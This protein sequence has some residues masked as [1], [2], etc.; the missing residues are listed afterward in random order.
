MKV[1]YNWLQQHIAEKLPEAHAL[2]DVIT[3][4]AFEVEEVSEINDDVVFDI[5]VLPDRA[6]DCLSHVGV[7]REIAGLLGLTLK[8]ET[9]TYPTETL[10]LPIELQSDLTR[11]Y[12]AIQINDVTV[13]SSPKWLKDKLET[14]GQRSINNIVDATNFVM[15]DSGQPVHAFDRAKID[16]G[17]VV[18]LAKP[19]E[20]ITTL[21]GEEKVL[22][23]KNLVIADYLGPL[24]LA[25]VKGGKVAEVT[26]VTKNI[27]LEIANFDAVSVRKTSR[28]LNIITDASKRFENNISPELARDAAAQI[29]G[30]II[31]IAGGVVEGIT[32]VYP[33]PVVERKL[34]FTVKDINRLLGPV[35]ADEIAGVLKQIGRAHV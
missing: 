2:A 11:R 21:S 26:E 17:I 23:E 14:L 13:G 6:G 19:G 29:V 5:N 9:Y 25:G 18:R 24:A 4:H 3:F 1:S 35:S 32:D 16:G 7:A 34:A 8:K 12:I 31:D 30:L 10:A 20:Q 27:V 28:S 22:S 33:A 15:L